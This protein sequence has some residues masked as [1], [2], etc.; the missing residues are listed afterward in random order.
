MLFV[1]AYMCTSNYHIWRK[2]PRAQP[3]FACRRSPMVPLL[4]AGLAVH[5]CIH[6]ALPA[7][8]SY[9]ASGCQC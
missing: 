3:A 2:F 7:E 9:P 5:S 6:I 4:G 1:C 8:P